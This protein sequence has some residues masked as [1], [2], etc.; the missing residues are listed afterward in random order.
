MPNVSASKNVLAA[1]AGYQAGDWGQVGAQASLDIQ[2]VADFSRGFDLQLGAEALVGLDGAVREYLAADV[3]GEAHAA[4]RVRAQ[5]QVP[6]DLFDEAGL[7]VRLQAVAEAAAGVTLAIG[8]KVGDFLQLANADDR[9]RGV[10]LELL[11]AF[12]A[13]FTIQGGVM[14]K[15]AAAAM[16]YANLALTGRLIAKGTEKPGFTIA[17]EAGVGLKAGAGFR[18]LAR[19]GVD[20]PRRWLRRSIDVAVDQ[21]IA[22]L[23]PS[24]PGSAT[25]ALEQLRVPAKIAL[26]TAFE[27]GSALTENRGAFAAGD[28][29]KLSL[30]CVQVA[31]EEVQRHVFEHA[32]A[33]ALETIRNKLIVIGAA[34]RSNWHAA[35]AQR[36][37]L[38]DHLAAMP[39]Y[40]FEA[41]DENL[42]YWMTL[43]TRAT[44]LI[45]AL[46]P[47]TAIPAELARPLSIVWS[48]VQ[49]G[50]IAL[51]RVTVANARVSLMGQP[52]AQAVPAFNGSLP[53]APD[54]VRKHINATLGRGATT[55]IAQRDA[56]D[57][58]VGALVAVLD[59]L[60]PNFHDAIRLVVGS[61]TDSVSEA[62]SIVLGNLGAFVPDA[63]GTPRATASLMVVRDALTAYFD[64]RVETDLRPALLDLAGDSRETALFADEVLLGSL[65]TIVHILFDRILTWDSADAVTQRN[66]RELCS[67]LVL[68]LAG[69]SLVVCGDVLLTKALESVQGELRTLATHVDDADGIAPLLSRLT[70]LDRAFI[71]EVIEE[72]LL[73]CADAFEPMSDEK[74]ARLRGLLYEVIDAGAGLTLDELR[75]NDFVPNRS[76]AQELA[77]MLGAEIAGNIVRFIQAFLARVGA[78]IL[79]ALQDAIRDLQHAVEQWIEGL[80][81]LIDSL[82]QRLGQLAA[83]IDRLGRELEQAADDL[84]QHLSSLLNRLSSHSGSRS[85]LRGAARDVVTD[86]A[87]GVLRAIGVYKRL[88]KEL[89]RLARDEL[90]AVVGAVL[91]TG[92]FDF[93]LQAVASVADEL[94]DFL[95]DVRAI[96]PGDDVEQAVLELFLDRL[97]DGIRDAFGD[98]D[99]RLDLA[100]DFAGIHISLGRVKIPL[101]GLITAIRH[102]ARDLQGIKDRVHDVAQALVVTFEKETGLLAAQA[103]SDIVKDE[104]DR[105]QSNLAQSR[106]GQPTVEVMQPAPG[107]AL[108]GPV[109]L[110]F[111]IRN[112]TRA[113]LDTAAPAQQRVFVWVNAHLIELDDADV[114]DIGSPVKPPAR[115]NVAV[116]PGL[117]AHPMVG[118]MAKA[119]RGGVQKR[120]AASAQVSRISGRPAQ[121][122][123]LTSSPL[124]L[125]RNP[126][127]TDLGAKLI[128]T[129]DGVS[130]ALAVHD[131]DLADGI[132]TITIAVMT[133]ASEQRVEHTVSFLWRAPQAGAPPPK[134]PRPGALQFN[135]DTMPSFA[136]DSIQRRLGAASVLAP[137]QPGGAKPGA[138]PQARDRKGVARNAWFRTH[139]VREKTRSSHAEVLKRMNRS[140]QD[141]KRLQE[142][143]RAGDLRARVVPK[144]NGGDHG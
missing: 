40:R 12:L 98:D 107:A 117:A 137:R 123:P 78:L 63:S 102:A 129:D 73:V 59:D 132:N 77:L 125:G 51:K 74:R 100:I 109:T 138:W 87:L 34:N 61:R 19:F 15:A 29:P 114:S 131:T 52:V 22:A 134:F 91:D 121:R 124:G 108:H 94:A 104:H 26:R 11:K 24:L 49:L 13:E 3:Q 53:G 6:L 47:R 42:A 32:V 39:E 130:I 79:E 60:G 133:G 21:S 66:V 62:L 9:M 92:I 56:V 143:V 43:V 58:L 136:K 115:V 65:R 57:F 28:G 41:D 30:R 110:R 141:V 76:A 135:F 106:R 48:A 86:E 142:A 44:D 95:D 16:A 89:R 103:E 50:S 127:P 84:L 82:A 69:R 1:G 72:T 64:Q 111:V 96:E 83:D 93:V 68:G 113:I 101:S 31:L 85:A 75:G 8:L 81:G 46:L 90:R 27:V 14:A 122:P 139:A 105:A 5:V 36:Q 4:A 35:Q 88:P 45:G 128:D 67:G 25:T 112:A 144:R 54:A 37:A 20:D 97:E 119:R 120:G 99:P 118:A 126:L 23:A 17:A 33:F 10:P 55:A 2:A 38:A 140:V 80:A 70:G 71:A 7:A 116:P 18:V